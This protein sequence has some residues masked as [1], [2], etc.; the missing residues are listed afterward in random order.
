M[1]LEQL[2]SAASAGAPSLAAANARATAPQPVSQVTSQV[3]LETGSKAV[4]AI[5]PAPS[6]DEVRDAIKKIEQVISPTAQ[7]LRF[8]IDEDTG[9]TVVKLIDTKTQTVLRQIPTV[10]MVEISKA[11]D[12]L[13]GLL[14]R[15]KA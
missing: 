10:E 8:S 14:V 15:E 11:L 1:A 5:Q 2:G 9:I 13:Q 12:K 3:A 6:T 4:Q 7:D